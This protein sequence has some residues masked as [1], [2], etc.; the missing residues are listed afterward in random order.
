MTC[1]KKEIYRKSS[2]LNISACN[3]F[4]L[5]LFLFFIF[6]FFKLIQRK[7]FKI[8][9]FIFRFTRKSGTILRWP[10]TPCSASPNWPLSVG[11]CSQMMLH[12][13]NSLLHTL[14]TSYTCLAGKPSPIGFAVSFK[15][16]IWHIFWY[17]SIHFLYWFK[18]KNYF[19][20]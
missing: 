8:Y 7:P 1:Y 13:H 11:Q 17:N 12:A 14:K 9:K 4:F 18:K 20:V 10:T 3:F 15:H 2:I 5:Y 19:C 16:W 6:Y